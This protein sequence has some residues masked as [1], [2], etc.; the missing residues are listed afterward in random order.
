MITCSTCLS[1]PGLLHLAWHH[2]G[3]SMLGDMAEFPSSSWLSNI[4]LLDTPHLLQP[5][6]CWWTLELFPYLGFV[7]N[8]AKNLE[9]SYLFEVLFSFLLNVHPEVRLLD[10]MVILFLISWGASILFFNK[11][12]PVH[13]REHSLA[14]QE[15]GK[16]QPWPEKGKRHLLP[17]PHAGAH[18]CWTW[19]PP[20]KDWSGLQA[21]SLCKSWAQRQWFSM[22][23]H[24]EIF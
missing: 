10:D 22:A 5:F 7:N 18:I 1:L 24:P 19:P 13:S 20:P 17:K 23:N 12:L 8:V 9:C 6:I 15:L 2:S 4:P 21:G 14:S 3:S 11:K 16:Q